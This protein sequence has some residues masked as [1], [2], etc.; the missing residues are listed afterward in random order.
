MKPPA[1]PGM[2]GVEPHRSEP[3][4][5][6]NTTT[7][8]LL[9]YIFIYIC[10]PLHMMPNSTCKMGSIADHFGSTGDGE[11]CYW[12]SLLAFHKIR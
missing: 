4:T 3:D 6:S 2:P 11:P 8:C 7:R 5:D 10:P 9:I 12:L 1:R